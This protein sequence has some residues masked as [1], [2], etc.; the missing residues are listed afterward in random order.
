MIIFI[1]QILCI[2]AGGIL[3][4]ILRERIRLT[5]DTNGHACKVERLITT[6]TTRSAGNNDGWAAWPVYLMS[7]S[8]V[9]GIAFLLAG[10]IAQFGLSPKHPG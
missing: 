7:S 5:L 8:S 2:G 4:L 3:D 9:R 6:N 1:S 10:F